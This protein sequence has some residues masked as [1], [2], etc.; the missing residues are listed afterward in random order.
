MD[1]LQGEG[2]AARPQHRLPG[3]GQWLCCGAAG[4]LGRALGLAAAFLMCCLF[5]VLQGWDCSTPGSEEI[6]TWV[7]FTCWL[8]LCAAWL[9]RREQ[10]TQGFR[11]GGHEPQGLWSL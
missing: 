4:W 7:F 3:H 11:M 1:A 5:L 6:L 2:R 9:L 10:E 8:R